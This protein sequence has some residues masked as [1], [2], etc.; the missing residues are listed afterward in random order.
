[1]GVVG[2]ITTH[3]GGP[4][5][6]KFCEVGGRC[7]FRER[8]GDCDDGGKGGRNIGPLECPRGAPC[9]DICPPGL[10]RCSLIELVELDRLLERLLPL[11]DISGLSVSLPRL[12]LPLRR[13][14][15][16]NPLLRLPL[17]PFPPP[18]PPTLP[19]LRSVVISPASTLSIQDGHVSDLISQSSI[20]RR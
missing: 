11:P 13:R 8:W 14:R 12:P 2:F 20:Q 10:M 9:H 3:G 17:F 18:P 5:S 1:M 4:R 16:L 15:R 6:G 19:E 7:E